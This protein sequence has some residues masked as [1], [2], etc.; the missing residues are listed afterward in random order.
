VTT[1]VAG[2]FYAPDI[3]DNGTLGVTAGNS[4]FLDGALGGHGTIDIGAAANLS[5]VNY[6]G[7]PAAANGPTIDFEGSGGVLTINASVLNASDHFVPEIGGLNASDA[8]DFDG[9]VTKA[10]YASTGADIGT[11]TLKDGNTTV[12]VLTLTG[13]DYSTDTFT[14]T[15]IGNGVTQIVDPPGNASASPSVSVGGPGNDTFVFHPGMGAE[16]LGNFNPKADTIDLDGFSN[17]HSLHQLAAQITT[18]AQ[19]DA[20]IALGHNDSITLPGV[21][22]NYLEAHLKSLVHLH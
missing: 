2:D 17:I 19:G 21:S 4:L 3:V 20:V 5:V 13:A 15:K 10:T 9:T 22:E 1:K 18:D 16:T 11:L 6:E 7:Q 8:I 12:A 14:A